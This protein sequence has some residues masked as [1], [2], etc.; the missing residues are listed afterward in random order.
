MNKQDLVSAVAEASGLTKAD[1]GKAVEATMFLFVDTMVITNT[2][3]K[4]VKSSCTTGS[5]SGLSEIFMNRG[6]LG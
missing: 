5:S 3:S 4:Y 2:L 6:I 1:A